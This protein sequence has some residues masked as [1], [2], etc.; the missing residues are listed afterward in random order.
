M[1]G[2]ITTGMPPITG[3][4]A[5]VNI[6]YGPNASGKTT[7][8]RAI[9]RLIR[10]APDSKSDDS[11]RAILDVGGVEVL[12]DDAFGHVVCHRDGKPVDVELLAPA[13][14]PQRYLLSLD[15]LISIDE[16]RGLAE[17]IVRESSGGYGIQQAAKE[18]GF[19]PKPSGR[20][21]AVKALK[22]A[23]DQR[24]LIE[25]EQREL[26][27]RVVRIEE[28]QAELDRVRDAANRAEELDDAIHYVQACVAL[29]GARER[30]D[31][32]DS[33]IDQLA[34]DELEK[35]EKLRNQLGDDGEKT[36]EL[37][38]KR[39]EAT[40]QLEASPLPDGGV[41][42]HRVTELK[43]HHQ[44][45]R[46]LDGNRTSAGQSVAS[47]RARLEQLRG[48]L[49]V[50]LSDEQL[51][52]ATGE[53]IVG[54][55]EWARRAEEQRNRKSAL[56]LLRQRL[57]K[58]EPD[59]DV[60]SLR[61]GIDLLHEWRALRQVPATSTRRRRDPLIIAGII[62]VAALSMGLLVHSSWFLAMVFSVALLVWSLAQKPTGPVDESRLLDELTELDLAPSGSWQSDR[63]RSFLNTLRRDLAQAEL[64]QECSRHLQ[65][66]D[67]EQAEIE[68]E[69]AEIMNER[70]AW[71]KQHG[72]PAFAGE[73]ELV[74]AAETLQSIV[75]IRSDLGGAEAAM[76]EAQDGF[77]KE[78]AAIQVAL[79]EFGFEPA[80]T[81]PELVSQI[82]QL[83][84]YGQEHNEAGQTISDS[85]DRLQ[86]LNRRTHQAKL[87]LGKVYEQV[88]LDDGDDEILEELLG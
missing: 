1:P 83:E 65:A 18:L 36:E 27:G 56:K 25:K 47:E 19:K 43:E 61:R 66:T 82:A 38:A 21:A 78:L 24:Q 59:V 53:S 22:T 49:P 37:E 81:L 34:G 29:A 68:N 85:T 51:D 77:E 5:G 52:N 74:F 32:F 35:I 42:Q 64:Q 44:R 20:T 8:S 30:L 10:A 45:L 88:G 31:A 7:L 17:Q 40:G 48:K 57:T 87:D 9:R 39:V 2:F 86:E 62:A 50:G 72:F 15:D 3:L 6:I 54:G 26:A 71:E 63:G 41:P 79:A 75:R 67:A 13:D 80:A 84:H 69:L 76:Q 73:A 46:E 70:L 60:D 33:R 58:D 28:L 11:L 16:D 14:L 4:S 12:I 55:F 23:T